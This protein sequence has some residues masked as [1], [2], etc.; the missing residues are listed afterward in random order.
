[1]NS[2]H[3][4]P[5]GPNGSLIKAKITSNSKI[6]TKVD[7]VVSD[8]DLKSV[9][10]MV[11]L[12]KN[13]FDENFLSKILS[14]GTLG[15]K[16]NR[17]LVPTRW[18]IT[19]VDDTLG[20]HYGVTRFKFNDRCFVRHLRIRLFLVIEHLQDAGNVFPVLHALTRRNHRHA[21]SH[22]PVQW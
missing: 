22:R 3:T 2:S 14:I 17:K 16:K 11:Y 15:I 6:H 4:A 8:I 19:A 7:K 5:T 18:G 13:D 20:C 9:D 21:C 1:M 10:A 12:H